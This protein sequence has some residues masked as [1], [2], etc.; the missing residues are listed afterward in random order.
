MGEAQLYLV[1]VYPH[2]DERA[3]VLKSDRKRLSQRQIIFLFDFGDFMDLCIYRQE[4]AFDTMLLFMVKRF[5]Y[6]LSDFRHLKVR[7]RSII[8]GILW[9]I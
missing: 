2:M 5:R 4:A 1:E 7:Q 9:V 8:G 6:D 3:R